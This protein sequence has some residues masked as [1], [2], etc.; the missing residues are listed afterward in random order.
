MKSTVLQRSVRVGYCN[1]SLQKHHTV[2]LFSSKTWISK[3]G[4]VVH[5]ITGGDKLSWI[6]GR[7]HQQV[8]S[9]RSPW[10][11][12]MVRKILGSIQFTTGASENGIFCKTG[13]WFLGSSF[14]NRREKMQ[15]LTSVFLTGR[16]QPRSVMCYPLLDHRLSLRLNRN[17]RH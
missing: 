15:M 4:C 14:A 12:R 2:K 7:T 8:Q 13:D 1:T 3:L 16:G 5:N 17:P 10:L 9:S 6:Q 11:P